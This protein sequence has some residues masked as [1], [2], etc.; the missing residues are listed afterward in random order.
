[1]MEVL[2]TFLWAIMWFLLFCMYIRNRKLTV[3]K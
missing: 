2:S 3:K 1:M